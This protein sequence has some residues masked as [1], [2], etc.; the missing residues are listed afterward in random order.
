[1]GAGVVFGV[2]IAFAGLALP[3]EARESHAVLGDSISTGAVAHKAIGFD[4]TRLR[5]ILAGDP[6]LRLDPAG[7][8]LIKDAGFVPPKFGQKPRRLPLSLREFRGGAQW[9]FRH[10]LQGFSSHYLDTEELSWLAFVA[11]NRGVPYER[12][13]V[14]AEDGARVAASVRQMDRILDDTG[15]EIPQHVWSF[16]TGNDLCGPSMDFVTS[17]DAF[18]EAIG[19]LLEYVIA[20][21]RPD[22]AGSHLWFVDPIGVLQL[23]FSPSIQ[24]KVV[25]AHGKSMTCRELH[26]LSP[27]DDL[28]SDP[29]FGGILSLLPTTP[30]AYCG[31]LLRNRGPEDQ[32]RL[33]QLGNLVTAYRAAMKSTIEQYKSKLPAGIDIHIIS[34]SGKMVLT[35]EDI[36]QDCFHLSLEGQLKLA[37]A[38]QEESQAILNQKGSG[39]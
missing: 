5:A 27:T 15:G 17:K 14:A 7:E 30:A 19:D 20:H 24:Q 13:L 9:V 10:L 39:S 11:R 21:G 22:P 23:A 4:A 2:M 8:Q 28:P 18:G 34:S 16:F 38:V 35:G 29:E 12:I 33:R 3:V 25:S 37:R 31:T 32:E 6:L 1:M 26:G 36:A